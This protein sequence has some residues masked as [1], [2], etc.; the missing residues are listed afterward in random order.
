MAKVFF[1][2][3]EFSGCANHQE[4]ITDSVGLLECFNLSRLDSL[5]YHLLVWS[6]LAILCHLFSVW[7]EQGV[8]GWF[9]WVATCFHYPPHPSNEAY[10]PTLLY[11]HLNGLKCIHCIYFGSGCFTFKGWNSLVW[12]L[13]SL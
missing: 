10:L 13:D 11:K 4:A 3:M 9:Y 7:L 6:T 2:N 12:L 1:Y 5:G 8:S